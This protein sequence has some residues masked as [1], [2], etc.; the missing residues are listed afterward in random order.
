MRRNSCRTDER[1][2]V[3]VPALC[4]LML[5][6]LLA[7]AAAQFVRTGGVLAS[8]YERETQLR[9]AAESGIE[10][11]AAML[12]RS[13]GAYGSMPGIGGRMELDV[14]D[15]PTGRDIELRVFAE[16]PAAGQL[17]LSAAAVDHA[18]PH[19]GDGERWLRGKIVRAYME[20]KGARYVWR[21]WF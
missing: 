15:V 20:E 2:V 9:L 8:E 10:T 5:M 14:G 13:S 16:V 3:S 12:E 19:I 1:G 11:A 6:L 4:A 21:R 17:Y 7:L 18:D